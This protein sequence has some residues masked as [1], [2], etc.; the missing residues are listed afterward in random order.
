MGDHW[1]ALAAWQNGA[2]TKSGNRHHPSRVAAQH[3]SAA[4]RATNAARAPASGSAANG[5]TATRAVAG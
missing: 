1:A 3:R 5:A 4:D 2:L